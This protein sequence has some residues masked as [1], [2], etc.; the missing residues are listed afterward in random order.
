MN[1]DNL[2]LRIDKWLWHARFFKTRSL[3]TRLVKSGKLRLNGILISKPSRCVEVGDILTFPKE[4]ETR[5]IEI[6]NLGQ[7]RGP[8][9]EAQR[10]YKDLAPLGP[11]LKLELAPRGESRPTSKER[12]ALIKFKQGLEKS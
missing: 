3:A 6:Y 1:D 12:K 8:A 10:L 11:K 9:P 2:T 4:L 5:V 7:R